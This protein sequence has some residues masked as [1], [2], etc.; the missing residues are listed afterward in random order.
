MSNTGSTSDEPVDRFQEY[1][2]LRREQAKGLTWGWFVWRFAVIAGAPVLVVLADYAGW[3]RFDT[4]N[5][6]LVVVLLSI[7][8]VIGIDA[9]RRKSFWASTYMVVVMLFTMNFFQDEARDV[10]E[11]ARWRVALV[12]SCAVAP[13]GSAS[14]DRCVD[15]RVRADYE[16]C[17]FGATAEACRGELYRDA[18]WSLNETPIPPHRYGETLPLGR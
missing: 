13:V 5:S 2:N 11:V 12:E 8:A 15:A 14:A 18:G 1:W 17:D 10:R 4:G 3:L 9:I 7:L 6:L 16:P